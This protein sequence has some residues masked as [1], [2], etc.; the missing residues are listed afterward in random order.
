MGV[1]NISHYN[2]SHTATPIPPSSL[3][4]PSLPASRLFPSPLP[5]PTPTLALSLATP[6]CALT[7]AF[8]F[9]VAHSWSL[10]LMRDQNIA[11]FSGFHAETGGPRWCKREREKKK[12][13]WNAKPR[14]LDTDVAGDGALAFHSQ[15]LSECGAMAKSNILN[16]ANFP[17]F[18]TA[19]CERDTIS[20]SA[21]WLS[22]AAE[23]FERCWLRSESCQLLLRIGRSS[24]TVMD[25][26]DAPTFSLLFFLVFT[27]SWGFLEF[28]FDFFLRI[29]GVL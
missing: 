13:D 6:L 28:V 24:L 3:C 2:Y 7:F 4:S 21:G 10:F 11:A 29:P 1:N 26:R 16:L 19:S 5:P 22:L 9:L 25:H 14:K 23:A 12:A 20:G 17:S 27:F 15:A 8:F 18:L